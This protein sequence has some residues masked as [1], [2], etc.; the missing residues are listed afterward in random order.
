MHALILVNP[1]SGSEETSVG[2][3][4][5]RFPD[6]E[7]EECPEGLVGHV[8]AALDQSWDF[9]GIAGGDGTIRSAAQELA[10]RRC[11]SCRF[12]PVRGS[13]S[14]ATSGWAISTPLPP[15]RKAAW[16]GWSTSA[17]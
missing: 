15:Q 16:S 7:V 9:I 14:L 5:K 6:S 10:D 13:T 12:R 4:A 2:A 1:S 11:P 8:R 17:G 3:L